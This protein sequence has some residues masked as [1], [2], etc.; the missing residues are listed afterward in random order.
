MH[1]DYSPCD[2]T[3]G[4]AF[5]SVCVIMMVQLDPARN[6]LACCDGPSSFT[7]FLDTARCNHALGIFFGIV[8]ELTK[9]G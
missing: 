6:N 4:L 5:L 7:A 8:Y 2:Q 1:G 9:V 3:E